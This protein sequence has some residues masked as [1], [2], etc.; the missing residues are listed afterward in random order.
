MANPE[1]FSELTTIFHSSNDAVLKALIKE[2]CGLAG[3]PWPQR[4][5]ENDADQAMTVKVYRGQTQ[6]VSKKTPD[7]VT[8]INTTTRIYRGQVVQN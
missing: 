5:Q 7:Q 4:L 2:L 1:L 3:D 6:L 8:Q